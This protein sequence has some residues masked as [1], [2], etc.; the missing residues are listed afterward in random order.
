ME[1]LREEGLGLATISYDST[2]I[3][4]VFSREHDISFPLLSDV[5]SATITSYGILNTVVETALASTNID[6]ELKAQ[7]ERYVTN[8]EPAARR[9]PV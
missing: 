8:A 7:V 4:A 5:G 3:L 2:E 9:S 6:P 1:R